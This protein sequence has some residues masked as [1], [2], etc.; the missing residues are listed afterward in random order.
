M[1]LPNHEAKLK[2]RKSEREGKMTDP[3]SGMKDR[4]S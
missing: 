2:I 3:E 1:V 4:K